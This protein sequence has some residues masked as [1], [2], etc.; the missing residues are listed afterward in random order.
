[1]KE[2]LRE[3]NWQV[4]QEQEAFDVQQ[5]AKVQERRKKQTDRAV[6]KAALNVDPHDA[7]NLFSDV[8]KLTLFRSLC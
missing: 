3:R 6:I 8:S 4:K 7:G 5:W 2:H 1:V